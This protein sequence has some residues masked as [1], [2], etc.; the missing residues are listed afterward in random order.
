MIE[1]D[2]FFP[3]SS[4][5][6]DNLSPAETNAIARA[7][8]TTIQ[9]AGY[10]V[11]VYGNKVDLNRLDSQHGRYL[12]VYRLKEDSTLEMNPGENSKNFPKNPSKNQ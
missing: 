11:I 1:W 7:F 9:E 12:E 2:I 6:A 8:C 5:S 4:W 3:T 10:C